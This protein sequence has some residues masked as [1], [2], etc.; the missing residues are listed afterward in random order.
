MKVCIGG[1]KLR[2]EKKAGPKQI[3]RGLTLDGDRVP[4][5]SAP[6]ELLNESEQRVGQITGAAWSPDFGKN[7]GI[8][9]VDK[10]HWDFGTKLT[11]HAPDGQRSAIV[12]PIP[13]ETA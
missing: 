9:M 13:F 1:E 7:I 3:I 2:A 4:G 8:G 10:D 12:G 11:V 6:W 5:C